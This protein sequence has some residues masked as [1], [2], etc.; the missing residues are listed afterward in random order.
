MKFKLGKKAFV[1]DH[2]DLK[3]MTYMSRAKLPD[4]QPVSTPYLAYKGDW[5]MALNDQ[6]G[7]CVWAGAAHEHIMWNAEVS[8]PV[9]FP[10][11]SIIKA[12]HDV[13]GY[14]PDDPNSDNGTIVRDA[15]G[16][17]QRTGLVDASGIVHKLSAYLQIK[18]QNIDE[19]KMAVMLFDAVGIGI[20]FPDSAMDQVNKGLPWTVVEGAK[21]DG[22]HYV[23]I[24]GYDQDWIYCIT[25]GQVQK[26]SYE[27]YMEYNDEAWIPLSSDFL[28][29]AGK[30]P[31]GFDIAT[32][33]ADLAAVKNM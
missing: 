5:G 27:F 19:L 10:D 18:P 29:V 20:D 17:R 25:W 26:M 15:M 30:S 32:L 21:S 22:G 24:V 2:R 3:M 12:Y 11:S 1:A 6:L 31:E 7:D 8:K 28:S 4:I 14:N 33:K 23:P 16:Y 13:A 9:N